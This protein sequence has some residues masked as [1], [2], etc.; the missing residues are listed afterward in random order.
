MTSPAKFYSV[1]Q[2]D[3]F[4]VTYTSNVLLTEREAKYRIKDGVLLSPAQAAARRKAELWQTVSLFNSSGGLTLP[5]DRQL[6]ME[7]EKRLL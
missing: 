2:T 4:G 1:I 3:Y 6:E 7:A 5:T